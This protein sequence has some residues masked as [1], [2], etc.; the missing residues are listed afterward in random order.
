M[1]RTLK[2]AA[3]ACLLSPAIAAAQV[4]TMDFS[5]IV[6]NN[7]DPLSQS[8]GDRTGL[9]VSNATRVG[10]GNTAFNDCG[11]LQLWLTGYSDLTSAVFPCQNGFVGELSFAPLANKQVT[12]QSLRL[13]SWLSNT[14]GIGPARSIS[15]QVYNSS[16]T[17]L[18]SFVGT[19]TSGV[20]IL[21]NITSSST[22]YL[23]WGT[24]WNT[25]LNLVKTN[26]S[27]VAPPTSSVPEPATVALMASGLAALGVVARKRARSA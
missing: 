7:F 16:W 20:D 21:P 23:Q 26:I 6:H 13:G 3:L 18:F 24:D 8:F 25:G 9:N 4:A 2:L 14:D 19:V 22:L 27:D 11:S 1:I 5:T 10:F 17:S 12:L 15:L